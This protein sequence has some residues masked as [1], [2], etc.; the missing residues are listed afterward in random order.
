MEQNM[1]QTKQIYDKHQIGKRI[2]SRRKELGITRQEI[3]SRIGRTEKYYADI[4]RGYCGM[5]LDTMIGIADYLGL[6][7]DYLIYG[8]KDIQG[9][10]DDTSGNI[11]FYLDRCEEKKRKKAMEILKIYLSE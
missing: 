8:K 10:E 6:E 11:R 5:S 3:A 7:L 4:E 2:Y 1:E 9:V